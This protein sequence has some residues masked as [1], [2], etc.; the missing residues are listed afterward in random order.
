M[1]LLAVAM[2]NGTSCA[3]CSGSTV[4]GQLQEAEHIH[5]VCTAGIPIVTRPL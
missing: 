2:M 1:N 4:L 5:I 3:C